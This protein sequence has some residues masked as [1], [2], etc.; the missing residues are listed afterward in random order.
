[1]EQLKIKEK[2]CF[3]NSTYFSWSVL[4]SQSL[5]SKD[6]D[7]RIL[8]GSRMTSPMALLWEKRQYLIAKLPQNINCSGK[9]FLLH[10]SK[11]AELL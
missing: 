6:A 5:Y 7:Y 9:A 11:I 3:Q 4:S 10:Y 8:G 2:K 1:M